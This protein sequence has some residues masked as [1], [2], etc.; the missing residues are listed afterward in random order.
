MVSYTPDPI[1]DKPFT[2]DRVPTETPS[3]RKI[4]HNLQNVIH[5]HFNLRELLII[6]LIRSL[7]FFF[8]S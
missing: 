5:Y 4:D 8:K 3:G 7:L 2:K 6:S 1:K